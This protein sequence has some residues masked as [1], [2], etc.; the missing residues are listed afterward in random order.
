[1][2]LSKKILK[3]SVKQHSIT[4]ASGVYCVYCMTS[5]TVI[6]PAECTHYANYTFNYDRKHQSPHLAEN[7]FCYH[8]SDMT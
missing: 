4:K 3:I 8:V 2:I 5:V 1:M 6:T 7:N